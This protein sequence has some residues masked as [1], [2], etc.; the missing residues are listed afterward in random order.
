MSTAITSGVG[1]GS[2]VSVAVGEGVGVGVAVGVSVGMG[3]GGRNA[4]AVAVVD[5]GVLIVDWDAMGPVLDGPDNDLPVGGSTCE[6]WAVDET[7][8]AI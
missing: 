2:G 3:V 1:V 6:V 4:V 7:F 8:C 5:L